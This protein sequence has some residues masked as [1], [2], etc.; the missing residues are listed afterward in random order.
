MQQSTRKSH[1]VAWLEGRR[2]LL[3][4]IPFSSRCNSCHSHSVEVPFSLEIIMPRGRMPRLKPGDHI[5][6]LELLELDASDKNNR[7]WSWKCLT[8][9]GQGKS[10]QARLLKGSRC[11]NCFPIIRKPPPPRKTNIQPGDRF[12]RLKITKRTRPK[13]KSSQSPTWAWLCD[14]GNVG[15]DDTPTLKGQFKGKMK[16]SCGKCRREEAGKEHIIQRMKFLMSEFQVTLED[17][18]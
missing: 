8:C 12:G 14:C 10:F 7:K 9:Q 2:S 4:Q 3:P 6:G 5:N 11:H 13:T 15:V 18:A 16:L 17:L 1:T